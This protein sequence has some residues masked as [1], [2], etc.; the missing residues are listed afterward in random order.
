MSESYICRVRKI[1]NEKYN[2]FFAISTGL[3]GS[4]GF[5]GEKGDKGED[6]LAGL[7]GQ[8]G[9]TG[10]LGNQITHANKL[11]LYLH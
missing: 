9:D 2:E 7:Q 8:K 11:R 4:V 10:P 1:W 3:Q 5:P 6:G